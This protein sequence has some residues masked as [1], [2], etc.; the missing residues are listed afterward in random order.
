[1]AGMEIDQPE[2]DKMWNKCAKEELKR[3][4]KS[5]QRHRDEE[6]ITTIVQIPVEC[7]PSEAYSGLFNFIKKDKID[8]QY[9]FYDSV[10]C[11]LKVE[12]PFPTG[13]FFQKVE[14]LDTWKIVGAKK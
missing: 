8:V 2:I 5:G 12:K 7:A 14:T 1:M 4:K 10:L 3:L 6:N 9:H 11:I 13:F